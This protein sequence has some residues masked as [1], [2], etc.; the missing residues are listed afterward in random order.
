MTVNHAI[1]PWFFLRHRIFGLDDFDSR[2]ITIVNQTAAADG[3]YSCP[4]WSILGQWG[5]TRMSTLDFSLSLDG[6]LRVRDAITCLSKFSETIGLEAATNG[7]RGLRIH[8]EPRT[9][10]EATDNIDCS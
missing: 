8:N 7:V 10:P 2:N 5:F 9:N 1:D 4:P 3:P 6:V